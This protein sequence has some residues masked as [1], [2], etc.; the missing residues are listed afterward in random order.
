MQLTARWSISAMVLLGI[1]L[2]A[3]GVRPR[4][5]S[6]GMFE[7]GSSVITPSSEDA[8]A[9]VTA[10]GIVQPWKTV[11]IK[12]S[13]AGRIDRLTVDLGDRVHRNQ[14][15]MRIDPAETTAALKRAGAD[16]AAAG[17]IKAQADL[18]VRQQQEGSSAGVAAAEEAVRIA[19]ARLEQASANLAA[20]PELTA[21][22]IR[23]AAANLAAVRN[24]AGRLRHTRQ[25]LVA[26]LATLQEV[27]LPLAVVQITSG[28]AQ[29]R[30]TAESARADLQRQRRLYAQ[31]FAARGQVEQAYSRTASLEAA[32]QIAAGRKQTLERANELAVRELQ[33]RIEEAEE[34]ICGAEA[35]SQE[36]QALL[37]LAK[38]NE[39]QCSLREQE[40]RAAEAGVGRA[41][42]GLE[43]AMAELRQIEMKRKE[44]AGARAQILRSQ[45]VL[46]QARANA[47]YTR[48]IAPREGVVLA[49]NVEEGTIIPS[50]RGSI[51]STNALLQIGDTS[52]LWVV[53][54][55][56]ET[57]L[58]QVSKGQEVRVRVDA[59][60]S[61]LSWGTVLRID[62]QAKV[63]QG[64]TVIPVTVELRRRDD[65]LKPGMNATCEFLLGAR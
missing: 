7:T 14:V 37:D 3:Y 18:G 33:S 51:G 53:C 28:L 10:T 20:Q 16:L 48:I 4:R 22:E 50:G 62:P 52:R 49:K 19:G 32:Y 29:A 36:A 13:V 42:A 24:S 60:S 38:H 17:A 64:V 56:D 15:L 40:L 45:S 59:Y 25:A 39:Y 11:D 30:A 46:D 55:V 9:F 54:N 57:D 31:G 34:Q 63:E 8:P 41:K 2:T 1:A 47:S 65:R 35:R 26:R 12:S 58:G 23:R 27:T 6:S 5:T 61:F 43:D 21:S 44:A